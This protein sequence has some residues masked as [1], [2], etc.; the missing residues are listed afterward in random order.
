MLCGSRSGYSNQLIDIADLRLHNVLQAC[1]LY[2]YVT[3]LLLTLHAQGIAPD[4]QHAYFPIALSYTLTKSSMHKKSWHEHFMHENFIF[5]HENEIFM[6][7]TD[8]SMHENESF[9]PIVF[10]HEKFKGKTFIFMY[11]Y[12]IFMHENEIFHDFSYRNLFV[13]VV[14]CLMLANLNAF[15]TIACYLNIGNSYFLYCI[16]KP[17]NLRR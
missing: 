15:A 6:H 1:N 10:M 4:H 16:R 5:M 13:R 2:P 7:E 8:I 9:P 11:G 17:V 3:S 14:F 12:I